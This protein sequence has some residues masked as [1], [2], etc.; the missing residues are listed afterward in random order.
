MSTLGNKL[1]DEAVD[2]CKRK[3][4]QT[5]ILWT[6]DNLKPARNLYRKMGFQPKEK[7][8]HQIWGKNLTEEKWELKLKKS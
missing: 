2:F 6:L 3:D 8:S 7:K 5:I 4:Y 1:V